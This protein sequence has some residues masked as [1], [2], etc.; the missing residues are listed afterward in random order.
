MVE[1]ATWEGYPAQQIVGLHLVSFYFQQLTNYLLSN[2][3]LPVPCFLRRWGARVL[4]RE[5]K[6]KKERESALEKR[7]RESER[8]CQILRSDRLP[9]TGNLCRETDRERFQSST[10]VPP[11]PPRQTDA[12]LAVH[13]SARQ[14]CNGPRTADERNGLARRCTSSLPLRATQQWDALPRRTWRTRWHNRMTPRRCRRCCGLPC[15]VV[16]VEEEAAVLQQETE[17]PREW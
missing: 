10:P 4:C 6:R 11:S 13:C 3:D 1:G 7:V 17:V 5:S 16:R 15:P 9:P 8:A 12:A 14:V 2:A